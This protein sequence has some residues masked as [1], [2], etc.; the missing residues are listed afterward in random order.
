PK[1]RSRCQVAPIMLS[2]S[3]LIGRSRGRFG[4]TST[5]EVERRGRL[6]PVRVLGHDVVATRRAREISG[7]DR[8]RAR[9]ARVARL[10][11]R[12]QDAVGALGCRRLTGP[13]LTTLMVEPGA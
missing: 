8:S 13:V 2:D 7:R 5:N 12:A 11:R 9:E 3:V 1:V 6:Q 4:S 10:R